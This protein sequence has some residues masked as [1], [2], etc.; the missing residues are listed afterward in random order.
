MGL[1]ILCSKHCLGLGELLAKLVGIL[2]ER[3]IGLLALITYA[4]TYAIVT[5][6]K[7][8]DEAVE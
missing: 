8:W 3:S 5:L 2:I 7:Y 6:L 4:H 1:Q